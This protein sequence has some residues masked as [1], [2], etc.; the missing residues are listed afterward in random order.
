MCVLLRTNT[1]LPNYIFEVGQ[2]SVTR[3]YTV[4]IKDKH[5]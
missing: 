1:S 4:V 2:I 5:G 3:P